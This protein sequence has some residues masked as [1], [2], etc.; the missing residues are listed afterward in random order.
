MKTTRV[1]ILAVF[2][3]L[4]MASPL[5]AQDAADQVFA[6]YPSRIRVGVRGREIVI[7]WEDSADVTAGYAIYRQDSFPDASSFGDAVLLGY[8]DSGSSG[9][10]YKPE[11]TKPHYYFV[12]GRVPAGAA[13]GGEA[14]YRL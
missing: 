1:A 11:D 6:P 7:A 4:A 3:A 14:E 9:F 13:A 10:V 8:S 2:A 12:L 5:Q